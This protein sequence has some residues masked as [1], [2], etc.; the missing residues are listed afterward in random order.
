VTLDGSAVLVGGGLTAV[1]FC[2]Y[3]LAYRRRARRLAAMRRQAAAVGRACSFCGLAEDEVRGLVPGAGPSSAMK[4]C[5]ECIDLCRDIIA[6]EVE[7]E[8]GPDA[9]SPADALTCSF[10]G[11]DD[12]DVGKLIAGPDERYICDECVERGSEALARQ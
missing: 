5:D 4:I 9:R 7:Q 11:Q 2:G 6:E 10:C 1:A 3:W 12:A 8:D